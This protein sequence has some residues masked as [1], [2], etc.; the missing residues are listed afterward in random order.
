MKNIDKYISDKIFND[1]THK[2]FEATKAKLIQNVLSKSN[3]LNGPIWDEIRQEVL[4]QVKP[5]KNIKFNNLE[6]INN[7]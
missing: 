4:S 6:L 3:L 5:Y 2:I 7:T 1:I